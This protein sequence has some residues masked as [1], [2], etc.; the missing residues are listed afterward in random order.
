[1]LIAK[2]QKPVFGIVPFA[3]I[4]A[5]EERSQVGAPS[6]VV[7]GH[8][9]SAAAAAGDQVQPRNLLAM[10]RHGMRSP[11]VYNF[12]EMPLDVVKVV[13]VGSYVAGVFAAFWAVLVY[14]SNSRRERARW[15]E[16]LYSRFYEKDELKRIR[17]MLDCEAGAPHVSEL[18]SAESSAWT[19]YLNF[20]E[21][22]AYLQSSKQLSAHDVDALF[23]YYLDCLKSHPEVVAYIRDREKGYEYLRK[24]L[25]NE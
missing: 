19:D 2:L 14:R 21:F 23:S 25:L 18:V 22:V 16:S 9:E 6:I 4:G 10:T 1:M 12:D 13:Q 8:G 3:A 15:A 11:E 17:D 7:L 20:F 5:G 24:V